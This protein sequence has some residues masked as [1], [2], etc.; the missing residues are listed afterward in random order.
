[1]KWLLIVVV[2]LV[3]FFESGLPYIYA[4]KHTP[5]G[6]Q[7]L[8]QVA[9]TP[10]Q[11]MYFSFTSQ[12]RDGSFV[13]NNKLT[14][15][16]NK[17]VFVNLEF[18]LVGFLQHICHLSENGAYQLWRYLGVLLLVIGV[19]MLA[20]HFFADSKKRLYALLL[21]IFSG[22]FG[23]AFALL[24]AVHLTSFGI[25]Q[26]GIIDM[27]YGLLPFQQMVTN[28]HFTFPHGLILIA[29]AFFLRGEQHGKTSDYILSGLLFII[30]GL[31]RPYDIIPPVIIFLLWT[32]IDRAS[33]QDFKALVRRATPL[34]MILPVLVY[35][36]WLFRFN[37]IFKYW[38]QQGLNA[39]SMPAPQWHYLAYGVIGI[40]AIARVLQI[41]SNPIRRYEIFLI[42]W[43]CVTFTFIHMG[44]IIPAI[45]WSPQIGVYLSVPLALLG[46]S[47]RVKG[48]ALAGIVVLCAVIS[49]TSIVLYF[50]KNFRDSS[51][52]EIYYAKNEEALAW[53]WLKENARKDDVV[54]ASETTALR[55]GKYAS[56]RVTAAHYSVT[57]RFA[58][59]SAMVNRI[60][61][62][63]YI[64]KAQ[65][66]ELNKLKAGYLYIGPQEKKWHNVEVDTLSFPKVY[67]NTQVSIY[68][69]NKAT[70][71]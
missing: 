8:G 16:P 63:T 11:N 49:N 54:L 18:W 32:V 25:T 4:E 48:Y 39:G 15:L 56:S 13:L 2:S 38:A 17:A 70:G 45:G 42:V 35:N 69:L 33:L 36:V 57:P 24:N 23:F 64:G 22:G 37:D 60:L 53:Q 55:I 46:C 41:K 20:N 43:F 34:L 58:E 12:A 5:A 14:Y 3:A 62:N 40:L 51:K 61:A 47:I 66:D 21:I 67:E 7:F 26:L 27:R 50:T 44:K 65:T 59:T 19:S 68:K 28:P 29:Y 30:I 52:T 71:Y 31:V 9:Y 1:M 6:Y 10:D